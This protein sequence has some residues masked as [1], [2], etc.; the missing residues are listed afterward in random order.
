MDVEAHPFDLRECVE[1]ALDLVGGRAAEKRLD[2]AYVFEG[3]V[4]AAIVGDV[5]RLRQ[6]LLNLLSNAVK[7]TDAGEVV[8]TV[9]PCTLESGERVASSSPC[10]TPASAWPREHRPALPE[11]QPGRQLDHP[12]VRRHR[13]GAGDQ[14][15]PGRTDGRND[16]GRE[17]RPGPGLDLPLHLARAAGRAAGRRAT[18]ASMQ[19]SPPSPASVYSSSTTTPPTARS[20]GCRPLAGGCCR[21]TPKARRRGLPG[22][23]RAARFDLAIVDMH[24]PEMDGIDWRARGTQAGRRPAA[25]A[26]HVPG[27]ARGRR[28]RRPVPGNA[29]QAAAPE[30]ALRHAGDRADATDRRSPSVLQPPRPRSIGRWRSAIPCASC[31][32]RT[33][34]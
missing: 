6:V 18:R 32:P 28:D 24:M 26:V 16:A 19:S 2:L 13:P 33:T 14:Q 31:W 21:R 30:P 20:C 1:S 11:L 7:F 29:C 34:W 3:E 10:A 8:L 17:C 22:C 27:P 23:A 25:G 9:Q 5:T 4:P 12:Q 15:A